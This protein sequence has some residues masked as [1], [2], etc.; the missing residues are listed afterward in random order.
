MMFYPQALVQFASAMIPS[1]VVDLVR[2]DEEWMT[3][4]N[5]IKSA[6][7]GYGFNMFFNTFIP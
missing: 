7:T 6:R 2:N 5:G 3:F 4:L 1:G